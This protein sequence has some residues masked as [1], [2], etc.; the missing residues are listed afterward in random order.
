MALF[1]SLVDF[2]RE[3]TERCDVPV[4]MPTIVPRDGCVV[5][6]KQRCANLP[7]F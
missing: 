4:Y 1:V 7:S 5:Y 2:R 3:R 6:L